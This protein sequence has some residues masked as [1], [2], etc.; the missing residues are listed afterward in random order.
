MVRKIM[1]KK[2]YKNPVLK[3]GFYENGVFL[4]SSNEIGIDLPDDF[5]IEEEEE[6]L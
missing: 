4:Q 3:I 6:S 1:V 2:I 5:W